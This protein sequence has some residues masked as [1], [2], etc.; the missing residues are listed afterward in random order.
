MV[1]LLHQT[2]IA[3]TM[4]FAVAP[5]ASAADSRLLDRLQGTWSGKRTSDN[6]TELTQTIEIAGDKLAYTLAN[7]D[8]EVRLFAKGTIKVEML[9]PFH[10]MKLSDIQ[11]GRSAT[12]SQ[13]VEDERTTV[14][15][16]DEDTLT[17]ASNFDKDRQNQKPSVDTYKR[18]AR[19]KTAGNADK[20]IG[21]WKMVVRIGDADR[22]YDLA[23]AQ[24]GDALTAVQTSSRSGDHK[25]KSVTFADGKLAMEM[26]RDI[27]GTEATFIYTGEFKDD[28]LAGDVAVKGFDDQYK[29]TWTAKR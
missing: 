13:A 1:H 29:G 26:V 20:L 10:V 8:R 25:F 18:T 7:S 6:G 17:L 11:A 15:I 16:L 22:D 21:K 28:G 9:G 14:Y 12:D 3:L 4:V 27:Q 2:L 5:V 24:A 19:P 23:F